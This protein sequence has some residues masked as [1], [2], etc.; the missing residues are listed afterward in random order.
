MGK[1]VV[2]EGAEYWACVRLEKAGVEWIVV[3]ASRLMRQQFKGRA[4]C[5]VL[6][7]RLRFSG[8]VCRAGRCTPEDIP[9]AVVVFVEVPK[10][11]RVLGQDVRPVAPSNLW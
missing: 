1:L 9:Q 11:P 6:R 5:G 2:L 4:C 8:P 3:T 7:D 10:K